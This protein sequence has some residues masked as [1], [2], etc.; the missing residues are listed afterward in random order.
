MAPATSVDDLFVSQDG[1]TFRAPVNPAVLAIG[2]TLLVKL[3][4]EPLIPAVIIGQARGNFARPIV[5]E[6]EAI[7]LRL[8]FGDVAQRP[9]AR[10]RIVL[11]GR[12]FRRQAERIPSHGMKHVIAVHPHI[13]GK[14]IADGI[15]AHVPHVERPGGI[16]QHLEDVVFLFF[17]AGGICR[18]KIRLVLPALEP[19]AFDALGIVAVVI[20]VGVASLINAS[21]YFLQFILRRHRGSDRLERKLCILQ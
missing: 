4:K 7:H 21:G 14:S 20:T 18:V 10:R 8:H 9:L 2:Q 5:G 1:A 17:G 16:R 12:V 19:F 13:A 6:A 15:V 3:E 11:D